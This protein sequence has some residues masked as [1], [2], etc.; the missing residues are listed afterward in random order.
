MLAAW[1]D[2]GASAAVLKT[3]F[4]VICALLNGGALGHATGR[5][6]LHRERSSQS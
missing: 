5:A 2:L 1:A 3:A 6:I 4:L